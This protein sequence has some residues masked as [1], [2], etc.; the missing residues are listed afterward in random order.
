MF[1]MS[2]NKCGFYI[3]NMIHTGI[4]LNGHTDPT[5]LYISAKIQPI[6]MHI[7]HI[8]AKICARKK[9]APQIPHI[10]YI[11]QL[12]F[13]MQISDN[14]VSIYTP[15]QLTAIN[16]VT[17]TTDIYIFHIIGICPRT[18]MSPTLHIYVLLLFYCSLHIK[19]QQQTATFNYH[20]ITTYMPFT[21]MPIKCHR[22]T[23]YF[24]CRYETII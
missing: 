17:M 5:V 15:Y 12:L 16:D 13:H 19:P 6:A 10:F 8:T 22:Y 18:N 23:N 4:M 14:Y 1:D 21:N 24:M 20:V 7:S 2:L 11:C 3:A 9:Y